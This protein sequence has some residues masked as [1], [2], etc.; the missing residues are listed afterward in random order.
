MTHHGTR[1]RWLAL[2][3]ALVLALCLAGT[4]GAWQRQ[5]TLPNVRGKQLKEA[6]YLL[7]LEGFD[8]VNIFSVDTD[9]RGLAGVVQ[10]QLPPAGSVVPVG[11][12]IKLS[13]YEYSP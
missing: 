1:G 12:T 11:T 2:G 13:V 7:R 3:A 10:S 5:G 9:K 4:A 6:R 8:K